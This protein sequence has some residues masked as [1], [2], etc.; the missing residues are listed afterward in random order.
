ML[1]QTVDVRERKGNVGKKLTCARHSEGEYLH[2]SLWAV[3][4]W[5]YCSHDPE[6]RYV[7]DTTQKEQELTKIAAS[8]DQKPPQLL[9]HLFDAVAR[10]SSTWAEEWRLSR[11]TTF[12][13]H[14]QYEKTT[15]QR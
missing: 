2:L 3:C 13:N 15:A 8:E 12:Q 9:G 6:L 14:I 5:S 4:R 11:L 7:L 10:S 1:Q